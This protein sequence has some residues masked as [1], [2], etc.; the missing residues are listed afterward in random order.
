VAET[1]VASAFTATVSTAVTFIIGAASETDSATPIY[2][3]LRGYRISDPL[4][5][6][7]DPVTGSVVTWTAVAGSVG[8]TCLVETSID[9]GATW[10]VATNGA[11]VPRLSPGNTATRTVLTRVTMT[12][13]LITDTSPKLTSLEVRVSLDSSTDELVAIGHGVITSVKAKVGTGSGSASG[14]GAGVFSTGGGQTGIGLSIK[15]K[16]V[17]PSR[18]I[19]KNGW[20]KPFIVASQPYDQA[21]VAMVENR[22]PTQ[23]DFSVTSVNRDCNLLIYGLNQGSDSWQDTRELA[24]ACGSEAFFDAAG[25]FVLRPVPDPRITPP[26]WTFD[27]SATCTVTQIER[28]LTDE[29]TVNYVIVKGE[30][31]SS[32]N[33]V[34][35]VAFDNDPGSPTYIYGRFGQHTETVVIPS[36]TTADQAQIA[37]NA[38]LFASIGACETTTITTVPIPFLECGDCVTVSFGDVKADG[39]YVVI[40]MTTPLSPGEAQT[41]TCFRQSAQE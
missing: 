38:I 5:L 40:S 33:P 18:A 3:R 16:C 9:F 4:Y 21:V 10:D 23:E 13:L 36:V 7:G 31:T 35:A 32:A 1:D 27:D 29:Q 6:T 41:L 20:E 25:A 11:A 19:S 12:R 34:S 2:S 26:V 8:S 37:A 14:S 30:S 28:E 39:R 22:L 17:D 24:T 15:I